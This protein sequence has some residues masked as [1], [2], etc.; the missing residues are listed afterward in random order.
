MALDGTTN[1]GGGGEEEDH[2][3]E[4]E[5]GGEDEIP[6]ENLPTSGAADTVPTSDGAG[7]VSMQSPASTDRVSIVSEQ[8]TAPSRANQGTH[9]GLFD[10]SA[11]KWAET[12]ATA[13][14]Q[15]YWLGGAIPKINVGSVV[16]IDVIVIDTENTYSNGDI[17][18]VDT[19]AS[20]NRIIYHTDLSG[21]GEHVQNSS[22]GTVTKTTV[23]TRDWTV[24][25]TMKIDWQSGQV[26]FYEDG[27]LLASHTTNVPSVPLTPKI[28]STTH[29]TTAPASATRTTLKDVRLL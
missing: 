29:N 27:T 7:G 1:V 10:G 21:T 22:A 11:G 9:G 28:Q 5:E 15:T 25:H 23:S 20:N 8:V 4:H 14:Y 12:P 2:A 3:P 19:D 18:L 26:D 13:D 24:E 6:V 16:E 17:G